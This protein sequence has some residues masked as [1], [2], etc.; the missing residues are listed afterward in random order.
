MPAIKLNACKKDNLPPRWFEE[1]EVLAQLDGKPVV[2]GA[3]GERWSGRGSSI[4][5][6]AYTMVRPPMSFTTCADLA[7]RYTAWG[8]WIAHLA[9]T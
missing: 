6:D 7:H 8:H 4:I 2:G 5:R 3:G 1:V 9:S